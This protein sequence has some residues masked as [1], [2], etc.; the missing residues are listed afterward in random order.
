MD[1]P[2]L[3]TA[4]LC[5]AACGATDGRHSELPAAHAGSLL[6]PTA[7][8]PP[9]PAAETAGRTEAELRAQ[10]AVGDDPVAA[11][12]ALVHALDTEERLSEALPVL[13]RALERRPGEPSLLV[14][15]AGVLRD[16]GRRHLAVAELGTLLGIAGDA[17]V[18]P[19]L[20]FELAE[21]Q[22]LE[23]DRSG[24]MA[25]LS[26]IR[27]AHARHDWLREH[28]DELDGLQQELEHAP[29]PLR[30]RARDLLGNLRGCPDAL[31]RLRA[32]E[33]L[34]RLGGA[35]AARAAAAGLADDDPLVRAAA[36]R[37]AEV[38]DEALP[39]LCATALADPAALVRGAGA[40]RAAALTPAN[41]IALLLPVL[42]AES[43]ADA[44]VA[45][46]AALRR[47]TR[48][49]ESV[50]S[51]RAADPAARA[52]LVEELRARWGN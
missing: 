51:E 44:F 16:L 1:R 3:A 5:L 42:A 46:C 10:L 14:A 47:A 50:S 6:A 43:D 49:G 39:E 8:P 34:V 21:L 15:R 22:W 23:G 35:V 37:H 4:C 27:Q 31:E 24:S 40:A 36:V 41:A 7:T 19:G 9:A 45:E 32:L 11:A 20:L 30:L 48:S 38:V 2:S 52:A 26:R 18:H 25:T 13:D 12:L 17:A 28:A 29:G 33:T